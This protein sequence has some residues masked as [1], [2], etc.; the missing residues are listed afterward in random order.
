MASNSASTANTKTSMLARASQPSLRLG[1][2]ARRSEDGGRSVVLRR[3]V[4]DI[5]PTW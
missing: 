4:R 3:L 5:D 2:G 1:R